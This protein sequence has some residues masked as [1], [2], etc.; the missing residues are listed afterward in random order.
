MH[1]QVSTS[2]WKVVGSQLVQTVRLEQAIH[3]YNVELQGW[4]KGASTSTNPVKQS[5]FPTNGAA[6]LKESI[7]HAEQLEA[8]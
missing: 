7:M 4:H 8:E 6:S 3:P 5:H 1:L 2:S